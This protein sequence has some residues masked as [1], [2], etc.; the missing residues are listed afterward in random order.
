METQAAIRGRGETL[1]RSSGF[2]WLSRAGFAARGVVY[3][4]IGILAIELARGSGGTSASQQGAL[5][6]IAD[7]PL[8]TVLLVLIAIGLGGYA[9]WRLVRA[10]LGHGPEGS[11]DGI[12][13]IAA[14]A[15]G[16]AYAGICAIA[17]EIL[18]GAGGGGSG[19]AKTTTAGV[20]GWPGGTWLV[21]IAGVVVIGIGLYQGY[22][23]ITR[24]FLDDSKT[25][26]MSPR[27]RTWIGRIGMFGY[28]A[29]MV[30]FVLIG[31]F[32]IKAAV[33]Y[34]PDKAVGLDGALAT[35]GHAAYGPILL[36]IV[37]AGFIAFGVYSIA[38]SRYRRI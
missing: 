28:V 5:K 33:D 37:A 19:R 34:N 8:G 35:V 38:D 10:F 2:E 23:G 13:R 12:E 11:D 26:K 32:L 16:V 24:N 22:R 27:A 29:R 25:E 18:L 31:S 36:A 9:L 4:V 6:S 17:V 21:V 20:L 7:Q 15:S 3:I 1:A 30:V 14:F